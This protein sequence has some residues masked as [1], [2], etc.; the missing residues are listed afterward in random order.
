MAMLRRYRTSRGHGVHSPLAFGFITS[1]LRDKRSAYYCFDSLGAVPHRLKRLARRLVRVACFADAHDVLVIGNPAPVVLKAL[2][3]A[4]GPL[5]TDSSTYKGRMI[6]VASPEPG[7]IHADPSGT[8]TVIAVLDMRA[9]DSLTA[10]WPGAMTFT[11][12]REGYLLLR[13]N[14]PGARYILNFR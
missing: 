2:G 11:N 6:V 12:G 1:T 5:S 3:E 14:L 13:R 8:L 9:W 10:A 4:V 7:V